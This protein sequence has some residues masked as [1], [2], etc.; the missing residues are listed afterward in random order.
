[1]YI[2]FSLDKNSFLDPPPPPLPKTDTT[3]SEETAPEEPPKEYKE[4]VFSLDIPVTPVTYIGTF[5]GKGGAALKALC[6]EYGVTGLHLGDELLNTIKGRQR[7]S[8]MTCIHSSPVRVCFKYETGNEKA[9][10]FRKALEDR[11]KA[12]CEKRQKHYETV[13]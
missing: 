6:L 4:E 11:A 7:L 2:F 3:L 9:A 10:E 8:R 5:I 13:R 1:M 12:V